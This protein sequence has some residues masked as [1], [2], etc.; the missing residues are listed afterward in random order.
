M[1]SLADKWRP[2]SWV[3]V[4]GQD[5]VVATFRRIISRGEIGGRAYW[6]SGKS[7]TGKT[8]CAHLV[9]AEVADE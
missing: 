3:E 6:F 8:T 7:G 1:P 2:R 9:A 5:K 4:V